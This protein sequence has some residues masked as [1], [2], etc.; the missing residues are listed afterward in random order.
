MSIP[1]KFLTK[2]P[3]KKLIPATVK[4]MLAISKN[5]FPNGSDFATET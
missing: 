1:K 3:I 2:I 5:L 4:L